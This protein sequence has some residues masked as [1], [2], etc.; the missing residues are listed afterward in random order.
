MISFGKLLLAETIN[1]SLMCNTDECLSFIIVFLNLLTIFYLVYSSYKKITKITRIFGYFW[2]CLIMCASVA[3]LAIHTCIFTIAGTVFTGMAIIAV[4]SMIFESKKETS[5]TFAEVEDKKKDVGCYVIFPTTDN[6]FVFGLHNKKNALLAMSKYKY[7]TGEEAKNA[8]NLSKMNG[9][10]CEFE[11][12]TADWVVDA[13]HPKFR[14]FLTE[15][16]YAFEFAVN[17][18]LTI[19]KSDAIEDASTC[20]KMVKEARIC[21]T[22]NILYLATSKK[23]IKNGKKFVAYSQKEKVEKV[24]EVVD[25]DEYIDEDIKN[26]DIEDDFE[27]AKSLSESLNEMKKFKSSNNINKQTLYEYL[28]NAYGKQ[29]ELNRRE[30]LTKTGLPLSDTYYT[31]LI[32]EQ[33]NGKQTRKKVCFAYVYEINQAC[34]IIAKLDSA[35]VKSLGN[36][37]RFITPSK[38]PR[39]KSRNWYSIIVNDSFTEDEIHNILET[40]K[41]YCEK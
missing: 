20:L 26:N 16:G 40:A 7:K 35:Y 39:S 38:F 27:N 13:K 12:L 17:A 11:D 4:L 2:S 21:V 9:Q 31:Y 14:M 28:N 15:K 3:V 24:E 8:I 32:E 36:K 1:S 37:R 10:E 33:E 19:L 6:N 25:I 30:N 5:T 23:D 41:G 29:V 34:M 18:K 22:S